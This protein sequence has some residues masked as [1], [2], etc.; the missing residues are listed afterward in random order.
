MVISG[1]SF[2]VAQGFILRLL[3]FICILF[4]GH[5]FGHLGGC[6]HGGTLSKQS[7]LFERM[8]HKKDDDENGEGMD[9]L[10]RKVDLSLKLMRRCEFGIQPISR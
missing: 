8:R 3:K 9:R 7:S 10:W 2:R 6:F 1:I 4:S 5:I